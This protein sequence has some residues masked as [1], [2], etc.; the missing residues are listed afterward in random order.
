[1]RSQCRARRDRLHERRIGFAGWGFLRGL[2][3]L[4]GA[5]RAALLRSLR[6]LLGHP[7]SFERPAGLSLPADHKKTT[8]NFSS[9]NKL[10]PGEKCVLRRTSRRC[11]A[12]SAAS[13][14]PVN[15]KL[16]AARRPA[17]GRGP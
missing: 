1:D 8:P 2:R 16:I 11:G 3:A 4:G 10:L 12:Q 5:L 6:T 15:S 14:G 13:S 9:Q 17:V 7:I